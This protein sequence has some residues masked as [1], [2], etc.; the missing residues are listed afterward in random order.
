[1]IVHG[2]HEVQLLGFG[3][4]LKKRHDAWQM[5]VTRLQA[6]WPSTNRGPWMGSAYEPGL[7]S[8]IVPAYNRARLIS[9]SLDSVFAQTYR[10][11]ELIVV[12]DGST[13]GTSAAVEAW[14]R[15]CSAD[16]E[17]VLRILR[18]DHSGAPAARNCGLARCGGEFIQFFDSDDLLH[19]EKIRRQVARLTRHD[20]VDLTYAL[21]ANFT[22]AVDWSA[23]PCVTFPKTGE[24]PL[25]AFLLGG[26]WLPAS[27]LFRRRA[28]DAVGPWD[29]D[30]PILEDWDYTIRLIL[31]EACLDFVDETFL[32]Y[33]QG[34]A[35]R[36]TVTGRAMARR[37]LRGRFVL[38]LRWLEWIRAAGQLD[39]DVQLTFSRQLFDVAMMCMSVR[40]VDLAREILQSLRRLDLAIPRSRRSEP[41]Y[42]FLATLPGWCSPVMMRGLQ[43]SLELKAF[44]A[45]WLP[46]ADEHEDNPARP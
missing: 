37:S 15:R 5:D 22:E 32:L 17:F 23:D 2:L 4:G 45:R 10:P 8:V 24:R 20:R 44:A 16:Q 26:Q 40:Q 42:L 19:P 28:C 3:A 43:R 11:L 12:D 14:N 21:T 25:T 36:P 35:V 41:M 18:Q 34:H 29:E 33:R 7:V 13:D 39:R 27:A 6:M 1:M 46:L 31:G 9:E 30:A 38:T